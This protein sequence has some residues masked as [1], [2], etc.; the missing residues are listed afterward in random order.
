MRFEFVAVVTVM[1]RVIRCVTPCSHN[2]NLLTFRRNLLPP[3]SR[4][5]TVMFVVTAVSISNFMHRM[6]II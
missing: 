5:K 4:C 3:Y 1:N 6:C 2:R